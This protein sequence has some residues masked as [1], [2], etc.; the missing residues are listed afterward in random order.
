MSKKYT[1]T[2]YIAAPGTPL[3]DDKGQPL[4]DSKSGTQDRSMVG[5]VYY[6]ISDGTEKGTTGYGF[7]PEKDGDPFG[8]GEVQRKEYEKYQNP[9]YERQLEIS[10]AQ[11]KKLSDYGKT[12]KLGG[13][14]DK[15]YNG[16]NNSCV[17]FT[18]VALKYAG[19]YQ[20]RKAS[21]YDDLGNEISYTDRSHEGTVKVVP[22]IREFENI[23]APFPNSP[24]NKT[25][26]RDMPERTWLQKRMT[27]REQEQ[28]YQYAQAAPAFNL[29][30]MPKP[31][32]NLY[33]KIREHLSAYHD[34]Y[35]IPIDDAKKHNAAVALSALAYSET[36][37]KRQDVPLLFNIKDGQYLIGERNPGLIK[38]SMEMEQALSFPVEHSLNRVQEITRQF[39]Q[40]ELERQMAQQQSRGM[41]IG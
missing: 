25:I 19:I 21:V 20:G 30:S 35:G 37:G 3:T 2:V 8:P 15:T 23:P 17:D 7:A 1:L 29:D 22:N 6:K 11:Y 16:L 14:D 5:H 40:Q 28:P 39:E 32:Q 33:P 10:E 38:T 41:S 12:P 13:F 31:F 34:K 36:M 26:H 4:I 9:I 27:E 24:L 18:F